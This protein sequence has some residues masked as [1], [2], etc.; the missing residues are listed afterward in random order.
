MRRVRC[1]SS[2]AGSSYEHNDALAPVCSHF[3]AGAVGI[4]FRGHDGVKQRMDA[5]PC[6]LTSP[7]SESNRN[8]M[9]SLTATSTVSLCADAV[10]C[11]K[12]EHRDEGFAGLSVANV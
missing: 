2:T 11:A 9:S 12:I 8:G 3:A 4:A 7:I 5:H 6:A 10:P 1:P